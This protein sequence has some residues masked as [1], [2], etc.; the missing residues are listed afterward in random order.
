MVPPGTPFM[1]VSLQQQL[2]GGGVVGTLP[3][4]SGDA[5]LS[6]ILQRTEAELEEARQ[7]EVSCYYT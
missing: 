7:R 4:T 6:E 2:Q 5:Q 3:S 1:G